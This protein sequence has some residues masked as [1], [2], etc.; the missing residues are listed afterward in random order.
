VSAEFSGAPRRYF[1]AEQSRSLIRSGL[2]QVYSWHVQ[3]VIAKV[4]LGAI[5][6]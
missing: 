1:F 6:L 4:K 2:R 3:V 5:T